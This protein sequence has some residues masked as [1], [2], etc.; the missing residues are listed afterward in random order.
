MHDAFSRQKIEMPWLESKETRQACKD[1]DADMPEL[2]TSPFA[3]SW[4]K[5]LRQSRVG[6]VVSVSAMILF[7]ISISSSLINTGVPVYST[8][9]TSTKSSWSQMCTRTWGRHNTYVLVWEITSGF[10]ATCIATYRRIILACAGL[11]TWAAHQETHTT[12]VIMIS[13]CRARWSSRVYTIP[14][15]LQF[16]RPLLLRFSILF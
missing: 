9:R 10:Q 16:P 4:R 1:R 8:T 6:V 13:S 2:T 12:L 3:G 5:S 15:L 7:G 14:G 11:T